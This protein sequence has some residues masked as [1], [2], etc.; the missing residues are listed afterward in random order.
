MTA[1]ETGWTFLSNA[2]GPKCQGDFGDGMKD[3]QAG[4]SVADGH[5]ALDRAL[6][7][8]CAGDVE[9]ALRKLHEALDQIKQRASHGEWRHF[10]T[11]CRSH[12]ICDVLHQDPIS[13]DGFLKP[14][15]YPGDAELIDMLYTWTPILN[16]RSA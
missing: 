12:A 14:R 11:G 8:L 4:Y 1:S 9:S 6:A 2:D 3:F 5:D 10:V 13:R 16:Q 15:G 7:D